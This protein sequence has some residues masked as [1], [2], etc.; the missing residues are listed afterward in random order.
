M[1]P[2]GDAEGT[3]AGTCVNAGDPEGPAGQRQGQGHGG[4]VRHPRP[5][6]ALRGR[7]P[8]GTRGAARLVPPSPPPTSPRGGRGRAWLRPQP[9]RAAGAGPVG[10]SVSQ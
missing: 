1:G 8:A 3:A 6:M 7:A 4:D 2:C 5:A 9:G 10:Q